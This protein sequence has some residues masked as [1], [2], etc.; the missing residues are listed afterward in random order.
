LQAI[1]ADIDIFDIEPRVSL[2]LSLS[3]NSFE[4]TLH[5]WLSFDLARYDAFYS[6]ISLSHW[7]PPASCSLYAAAFLLREAMV[8]D[9]GYALPRRF[10]AAGQPFSATKRWLRDASASCRDEPA[11]TPRRE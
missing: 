9:A 6:I 1:F 10:S 5:Y 4:L 3:M 7:L 8:A 2:S 11:A